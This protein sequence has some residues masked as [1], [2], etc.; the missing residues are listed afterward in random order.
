MLDLAICPYCNAEIEDETEGGWIT[1]GRALH[2]SDRCPKCNGALRV[3]AIVKFYLTK[4]VQ[5]NG[6][7]Q[8]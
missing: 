8:E 5:E 1:K 7:V 4:E 6:R 2:Y 3:H